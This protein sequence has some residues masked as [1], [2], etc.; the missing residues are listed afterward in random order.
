MHLFIPRQKY[1]LISEHLLY[2]NWLVYI[3]CVCV[4]PPPPTRMPAQLPRPSSWFWLWSSSCCWGHAYLTPYNLHM[5]FTN[6][7]W[8]AVE[9][10]RKAYSTLLT[11]RT[12]AVR[13]NY[14]ILAL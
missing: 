6:T 2:Y 8:A 5:V 9:N 3:L 10:S 13:I 11:V 14:K 1:I 12:L 7:E 4:S